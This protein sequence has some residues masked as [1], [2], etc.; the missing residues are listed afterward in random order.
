[1]KIPITTVSEL[2]TILEILPADATLLNT[3]GERID[4]EVLRTQ[5]GTYVEFS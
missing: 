4:V 1:M 2:K 3:Y 5:N